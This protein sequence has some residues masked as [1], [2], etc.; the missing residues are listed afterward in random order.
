MN[1]K[2][3]LDI[4]I[5]VGICGLTSSESGLVC[6][7][8]PL[9]TDDDEESPIHCK[10]WTPKDVAEAIKLLK[11]VKV[12]EP[13]PADPE[14]IVP[15]RKL[16]GAPEEVP[17]PAVECKFQM[18]DLLKYKSSDFNP[19][20]HL[21]ASFLNF[22]PESAM[23]VQSLHIPKEIAK[24]KICGALEIHITEDTVG[25]I[26]PT[27]EQIKNLKEMLCIDVELL[28]DEDG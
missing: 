22:A 1:V 12:L 2:Q 23:P 25:F 16:I 6:S 27:P 19:C 18:D 15:I 26:K 9:Y 10:S 14:V 28:E 11:T 5:A 3:A 20:D 7:D 13:N 24:I 8:C 17:I 21:Q 4:L